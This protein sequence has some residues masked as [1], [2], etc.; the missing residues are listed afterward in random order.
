MSKVTQ[1]P[2]LPNII[3]IR[4][5]T[6]T[7]VEESVAVTISSETNISVPI[8]IEASKYEDIGSLDTE[9]EVITS[10]NAVEYLL[11]ADGVIDENRYDGNFSIGY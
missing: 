3:R 11:D 1:L 7:G 8:N 5:R 2:L 10:L 9:I 6:A 4:S